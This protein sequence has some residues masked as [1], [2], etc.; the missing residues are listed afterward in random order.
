MFCN[1]CGTSL[2]DDSKFCSNCG[3]KLEQCR[4]RPADGFGA[5]FNFGGRSRD[6]VPHHGRHRGHGNWPVALFIDDNEYQAYC[7]ETRRESDKYDNE[8]DCLNDIQE[9]IQDWVFGRPD[10]PTEQQIREDLHVKLESNF[11]T[12]QIKYVYIDLD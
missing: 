6:H 11:K 3:K 1:Y 4:E 9:R 7:V 10:V 8:E 5:S 12:L 2:S